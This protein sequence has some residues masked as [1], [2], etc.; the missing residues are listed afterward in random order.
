[1]LIPPPPFPFP[2]FEHVHVAAR[3]V[4]QY[5][6]HHLKIRD[7]ADRVA[8][9]LVDLLAK[10]WDRQLAPFNAPTS[11]QAERDRLDESPSDAAL[12][13][14]AAAIKRVTMVVDG[15]EVTLAAL[16]TR[17]GASIEASAAS[18]LSVHLGSPH[19]HAHPPA[20]PLPL[21]SVGVVAL[22]TCFSVLISGFPAAR[23]DDLGMAIGCGTLTPPFQIVT[24]SSK[25][26][27]G[28]K[29]AA[30]FGDLT[31][32]CQPGARVLPS[33]QTT[34]GQLVPAAKA[35][36]SALAARRR[37]LRD[38]RH[39]SDAMARASDGAQR[40]LARTLA[41]ESQGHA[42][43]TKVQAAQAA[44]SA[45]A[46]AASFL[47]GKDPA[48][49]PCSGALITGDAKVYI[50]GFPVSSTTGVV[51]AL[52]TAPGKLGEVFTATR[53]ALK[54]TTRSNLAVETLHALTAGAS[55]LGR[56]GNALPRERC[57]F[58]GH[59][60]DVV[61]GRLV[62][63]ACDLELPGALPLRL[64]RSYS[65]TWSRRRTALGHGWSH[66]LD[67]AV[68][69]EPRHLVY[70]AEDGRELEL[71]P[72][73]D[74]RY[75][76]RH[77]L[78][79]RRLPDDRWQLEDR[80]GVRR[81]F[82]AIAGDPRPGLLRLIE[83]RDRAGHTLRC[84]Y[85]A[86]ARL[87][88]VHA[89]GEREILL[90]Y[91]DPDHPHAPDL[92]A[93]IDLPDPDGPGFVPHVRY[94]Y[95]HGDLVE[96]HDAL[97]QVTRYRH[98]RH[99]IVEEQLPTG[100][101]F[102]FSYES[103]DPEAA[104]VRTWGDGGI[105]DHRLIFDRARR[106]TLVINACQETTIY[107]ADPRGLVV[108][109][110]DPRGAVTRFAHDEHLNPIEIVDPLGH[111]T[112]LEY[113]PRGNLIRHHAPDGGLTT[114]IHDPRLDLPITRTDPAGG[115]WRWTHD[116]HGRLLRATDPLGR[117]T[118]H[119]HEPSPDSGHSLVTT[120]HPDGQSERRTLD[121]AGRLLRVDRSDGSF[122][123]H[124][125]DRRGRLR[126]TLDE[127]GRVE[128]RDLDLLGRLTR[129]T[130]PD[131][132]Q[133]HFSHDPAGHVVRACD[134]LRDLHCTYSGLGW[135]ATCSDGNA[136]PL[137]LE[138]DLEGRLTRVAGPAGTLL[139]IERDPAGRVR[140]TVDVLGVA[141]RHTRDLAGRLTALRVEGATTTR[142]TRDSAGRIVEVLHGDGPARIRDLL[143]Y[144]PDGALLGA[145]RHHPDGEHSVVQRELDLLGRVVREQQDEHDL[146]AEYD[147][148]DRLVRLRSS[149]GA[150][151]HF[152]HD[153]RGLTRVEQ[154][155]TGWAI[156]FE[157]DR[158]GRERA[159]QLPGEV[160]SWWQRDRDG[161]PLEHG[162]VAARPPQI[163]RQR[164]YTW[165]P[166]RRLHGVEDVTRRRSPAP[167]PLAPPL[168]LA[169]DPAGRRV[170]AE[171]PDG[172]T[173]T[174]HHN[175]A[176]EL[177]RAET[178]AI[179]VDYRHDALGRR[180]ARSRD[181]LTTRWLWHGDVPLHELGP[182]EHITWVFEPG[183]FAPLARLGATRHAVVGDHL[184]VPLALLDERGQLAWA[185]DLD[186]H[187]QPRPIRGDPG[188]CPFRFPGQI[189]DPDTGLAYNRFRDHD[190]RT[191]A[192]LEPDPLGLLG[193]LDP[194][195]YVADPRSETDVF[196]L[197]A[198][199]P[200]A[201]GAHARVAAELA[202][203]FPI[204]DLPPAI[205][206]ALRRPVTGPDRQTSALTAL[207][208]PPRPTCG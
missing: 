167:L 4:K 35:V 184:G 150:D 42:L 140:R 6:Q 102:Y 189:A 186:P 198:D 187:H 65:S 30:R 126:R 154:A 83:R 97:G 21:P 203:D 117:S 92:L 177:S 8:P 99:R 120:L 7:A 181:G 49:S 147:V 139:R 93:R 50:G 96:V 61:T 27:I 39:A 43:A 47:V 170:R 71:E 191:R 192:Y 163:H 12:R 156:A 165:G 138:R 161:R 188:L 122:A 128:L 100:L 22:G 125:L 11:R 172:A 145:T 118:V 60:V 74:E 29:R 143:V 131:G 162:L 116:P 144:R 134:P 57:V 105:I 201:L 121:P 75:F 37:H 109:I 45:A 3:A 115:Q 82:A 152:S 98:R 34:I 195:A 200:P 88:A 168:A 199:D 159:R 95:E 164:R 182:H 38:E 86:R 59:P 13:Q 208:T 84:R 124:T 90:H 44:S 9:P 185:A 151:L 166:D 148:Q 136:P 104:C 110:R 19:T 158:D 174:Y 178:A 41:A 25:V 155:R 14:F 48:T 205:A 5:V 2:G 68:W 133:R 66:S 206:Q 114:T 175:A 10:T 51:K 32:H 20:L 171:L 142:F 54:A 137:T 111:I 33:V 40:A 160:L 72:P 173:W 36:A 146:R 62:L 16:T 176:G 130:L 149:A 179:A 194:H 76:P 18:L 69:L 1:M 85:D 80:D 67:E 73:D 141:R 183:G 207:H 129:H 94:V 91:N 56:P 81:D 108:E 135:L 132:L 89:D 17:W 23:V 193:G 53:K 169:H 202:A 119:H 153:G 157:R 112:R 77:R 55:A 78:T 197:S 58:T 180:I 24:G 196:G 106:T 28:G 107:R 15:L 127:R 204:S 46:V 113:D 103:D 26:F 87:I 52:G 123:A 70:R 79:L 31:R 101:R 64:T 190:P 63:D